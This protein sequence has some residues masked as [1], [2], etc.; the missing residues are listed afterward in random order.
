MSRDPLPENGPD[1]F[2][3]VPHMRKYGR[4]SIHVQPYVYAINNPLR[5]SDPSG[6]QSRERCAGSF[7][8]TIGSHGN[9]EGMTHISAAIVG[10]PGVPCYGASLRLSIRENHS[11]MMNGR[12]VR[13]GQFANDEIEQMFRDGGD[14]DFGWYDNQSGT[15]T[16]PGCTVTSN[17]RKDR[18]GCYDLLWDIECPL[19][20][21]TE[22]KC[23]VD[24]ASFVLGAWKKRQ[25]QPTGE[26][27]DI[28]RFFM[29]VSLDI[30]LNSEC[31]NLLGCNKVDIGYQW[32]V[33]QGT[34]LPTDPG[35][36]TP[37]GVLPN[38]CKLSD[39]PPRTGPP[40]G[41]GNP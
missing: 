9:S 35:Q 23:V 17:Y 3:P 10:G 38:N 12:F 22:Q 37:R 19:T 16:L 25:G 27:Y 13:C 31:C 7:C 26:V 30:D 11:I 20:C 36:I 24:V 41:P 21:D 29:Q 8:S 6:L 1:I 2:Y 4:R 33:G 18:N 5:Y 32:A 14:F 15:V 34:S 28:S 40:V 39:F